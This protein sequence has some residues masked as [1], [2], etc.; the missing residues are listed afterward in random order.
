MSDSID[1]DPS[2]VYSQHHEELLRFL[3]WTLGCRDSA[4]DLAQEAYFRVVRLR[5]S[6]QEV[7]HP[8]RFL[9]S[10]ASNL[11]IDHLR[12]KQVQ[13]RILNNDPPPL[14]LAGTEPSAD[15]VLYAKERLELVRAAITTLSPKCRQAL[16]LNRIEGRTHAEIARELGVSQSMVGKY[17]GQA[18]RHCRDRLRASE[19]KDF[20]DSGV[21]G[22]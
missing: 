11:V 8:R 16:F 17:I 14:E 6:G 3:T 15:R 22:G 9:F 2:S 13:R 7:E 12:K 19:E 4:A 10:V 18:L 5:S 21:G 1:T 20:N